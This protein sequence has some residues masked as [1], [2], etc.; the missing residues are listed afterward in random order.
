MHNTD[1]QQHTRIVISMRYGT[2]TI[3][4]ETPH[5]PNQLKFVDNTAQRVKSNNKELVESENNFKKK[6]RQYDSCSMFFKYK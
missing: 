5:I 1:T 2:C 3:I 6:E 4:K